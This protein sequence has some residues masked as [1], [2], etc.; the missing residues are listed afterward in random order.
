MRRPYEDDET[1]DALQEAV[2]HGF[3]EEDFRFE[4]TDSAYIGQ[5][6]TPDFYEVTAI[7]EPSGTEQTFEAGDGYAWPVEFSRALKGG[8]F[9]RPK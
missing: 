8:A 9:G 2:R 6:L 4:R 3:R 7:H 5:G 1:R